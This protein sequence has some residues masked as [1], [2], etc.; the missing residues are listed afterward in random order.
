MRL[1]FLCL[2]RYRLKIWKSKVLTLSYMEDWVH[3]PLSPQSQISPVSQQADG[4]LFSEKP[5]KTCFVKAELKTKSP[6][7]EANWE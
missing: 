4:F 2:I 3:R 1:K 5:Y 6:M 7:S